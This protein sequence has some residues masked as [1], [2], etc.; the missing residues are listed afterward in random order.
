MITKVLWWVPLANVN[1]TCTLRRQ[2]LHVCVCVCVCVCVIKM[3]A[4]RSLVAEEAR[5][6]GCFAD[7]AKA[8]FCRVS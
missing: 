3:A 2:L 1:D 7:L 8:K 4:W 5:E 6:S